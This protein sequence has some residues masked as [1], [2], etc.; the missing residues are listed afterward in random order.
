MKILKEQV[1]N[2]M[3]QTAQDPVVL[4]WMELLPY[5]MGSDDDDADSCPILAF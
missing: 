4:Q 2:G 3:D 5:I 1:F